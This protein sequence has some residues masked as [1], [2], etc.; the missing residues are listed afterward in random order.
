MKP[1][2]VGKLQTKSYESMDPIVKDFRA[3]RAQFV[4]DGLFKAQSW[5]YA[6]HL[7]QIFALEILGVVL[8]YNWGH[9]H[10]AFW[11]TAVV[12]AVSQIQAGWLQHD[13]GHLS[14]V[15]GNRWLNSAAHHF[16]IGGLKGAS[17]NWWKSRHNRH[18]AKTNVLSRDP[19]IHTEPIF[20]WR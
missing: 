14:V 11:L 19:D 10:W 17:S 6:L 8:M 2:L 13:F 1:L 12:L 18:H 5:W 7:L 15:L 16:V 4:N 20:V 3:L 9:T